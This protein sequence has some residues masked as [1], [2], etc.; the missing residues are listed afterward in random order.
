MFRVYACLTTQHDWRLVGVAAVICFISSLTA[1]NLFKRALAAHGKGR[2]VWVVVSGITTGSGIWATHFLAMLAYSPG[3]AIEYHLGLTAYSLGAAV[4]ITMLGFAAATYIPARWSAPLGGAIVGAGGLC[5]HYIGMWA[6]EVPGHLIWSRGLIIASVLLGLGLGA[7]ALAIIARWNSKRGLLVAGGVLTLAIVSLHFVGISSAEIISDPSRVMAASALPPVAL[8]VAVASAAIALRGMSLISAFADGLLHEKGALVEI[9]I[10][11]MS[12]GLV[13]FD[14]AER[15]VVC[16]DRYVELYGLSRDIVK[17][18]CTLRDL[19]RHRYGTGSLDLD[20]EKY[21][22][23]I[24]NSVNANTTYS[25]IVESPDGR[26]ISVINKPIVGGNYW[27]GTHEDIT[28]RRQVEKRNAAMLE[29]EQ[30]RATVD[31]AILEFRQ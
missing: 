25:R 31:A 17:P 8:A 11:N 24:L 29:Q 22:R 16:N 27:V 4:S 13:M 12:Q 2:A 9:A 23:E 20:V 10:N 5:M 6:M 19:I 26:S 15:L 1:I 14:H 28:E 3:V 21:R 18:G 30:R 7:A